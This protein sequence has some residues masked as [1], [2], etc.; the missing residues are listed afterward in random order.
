MI[1]RNAGGFAA[2]ALFAAMAA[3]C[4]RSPEES[5]ADRAAISELA[6]KIDGSARRIE[7]RTRRL[8]ESTAQTYIH[9]DA[10]ISGVDTSHYREAAGGVYY[11]AVDDGGPALWVSGVVPVD[12]TIRRIAWATEGIDDELRA[13]LKESPAVVQAYYNDR[14]SLNRIYPPFDV[15]S[16]YEPRMNI[17]EFNFYYLADE[18]HNP[19]RKVV[20][21]D[22][23]YVDPAGRGWMVSSIAPVYVSNTLMGVVG[24]D[25]TVDGIVEN[26]LQP[27]HRAWALVDR[28]GTIV[29]ATEIA[30]EHLRMPPL[31][32]HRYINTVR[33]DRYRSE[34]YNMRQSPSAEVRELAAAVLD[35][36]GSRLAR[37]AGPDGE[38]LVL[39]E[40]IP[41]LGWVALLLV[42]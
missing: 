4:G 37:L 26:F 25:V 15:L 6:R 41:A 29:A 36:D 9:A 39:V 17:P 42:D 32:D 14:N 34:D 40:P 1:R 19:E 12:D 20:W 33:S 21:V 30:V 2:L 23:P 11:K 16:Q 22:E 5:R 10:I 35:G 38:R 8:A 24:L 3:G 28:K 18:T 31:T 7:S 27:D 13:M